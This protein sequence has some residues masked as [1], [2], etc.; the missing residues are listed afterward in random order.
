[1]DVD[2]E[3][4]TE[5]NVSPT[6]NP[7][8][9]QLFQ[10][11]SPDSHGQSS[12]S[13]PNN[14]GSSPRV[15][16]PKCLQEQDPDSAL[17]WRCYDP[18][19]PIR[20]FSHQHSYPTLT[21]MEIQQKAYLEQARIQQITMQQQAQQ[22]QQTQ[23]Q[24]LIYQQQQIALQRQQRIFEQQQQPSAQS[25]PQQ[26]VGPVQLPSFQSQIGNPVQQ[27]QWSYTSQQML[28]QP[29]SKPMS[30]VFNGAGT[31]SNPI[32]LGDSPPQQRP[33]QTNTTIPNINLPNNVPLLNN[34]WPTQYP[35]PFPSND[36]ATYLRNI[37]QHNYSQG[38]PSSEEL[39]ELLANIRPDED[40]KVEDKDAIVPGFAGHMRLLK[41]QQVS[42]ILLYLIDS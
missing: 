4:K 14:Q 36:P 35:H 13:F 18:L 11:R 33:V 17:C 2:S 5:V 26:P 27:M 40:I 31:S 38:N 29:A 41:H 12:L 20:T 39:K 19:T 9:I 15:V 1:M 7:R 28:Q 3:N 30:Y 6:I 42:I 25:T 37:G 8:S 21:P 23:Q 34:G 22:Q 10:F 24:Q 16:C 32:N